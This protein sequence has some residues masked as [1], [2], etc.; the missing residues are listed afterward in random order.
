MPCPACGSQRVRPSRPRG[1]REAYLRAFTATRYHQC[2]DCGW[3]ARLPRTVGGKE[4]APPDL[5]FWVVAAI[6]GLGFL[7]VLARVG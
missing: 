4:K 1:A 7:Y 2:K 3:R 6:V 5:R